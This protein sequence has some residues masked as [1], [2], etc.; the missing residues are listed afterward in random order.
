MGLIY[1]KLRD[2]QSYV[3]NWYHKRRLISTQRKECKDI[4]KTIPNCKVLSKDEE[5]EIQEYYSKRIGKKVSTMWHRL[6][7]EGECGYSVD[8]VPL[9]IL[10]SEIIPK[11][12]ISRFADAYADKSRYEH[13]FPDIHHPKTIMKMVNGSIYIDDEIATLEKLWKSLPKE[14]SAI[15]KPTLDTSRGDGVQVI[16]W[17]NIDSKDKLTKLL[18]DNS[19]NFI[20]Q[21]KIDSHPLIKSLNPSSLNTLRIM[22]YRKDKEVYILSITLKIGKCGEIVDNGHHGGYFCGVTKDGKLRKYIYTLDPFTK[23]TLTE[24]GVRIEGKELP[25]FQKIQSIVKKCAERL[26]YARYIGWDIA[27]RHD[28]EPVLIEI[29]IKGPGGN[30]MQIPNGPL[31]GEYRDIILED[32]YG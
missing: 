11:L 27:I 31:F 6:Y 12:N 24:N 25:N 5:K 29:N 13:L 30:I 9:D 28:G 7:T 3:R 8:Y 23:N 20:I 17:C 19:P 10:F 18:K 2:I 32:I 21:E 15:L 14:G 16:N 22:T 4:I 26:P 1:T